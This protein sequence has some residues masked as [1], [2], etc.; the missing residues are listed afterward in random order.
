MNATQA[1]SLSLLEVLERQG[2]SPCEIRKAGRELW[3]LSPFRDEKTP[4]FSV[5]V[6]KNIWN[7]F[8]ESGV[9]NQRCAGGKVI[10][11]LIRY[12]NTD[13][14]DA[15]AQVNRL[16]ADDMAPLNAKP[17]CY[18][19][20]EKNANP[21]TLTSVKEVFSDA[22]FEYM[23]SRKIPSG[24]GLKYLK[25]VQYANTDTGKKN[26]GLGFENRKG[27]YE[28]RNTFFKGVVGQKD[29]TIIKG[30]RDSHHVQLIEGMFDFLSLLRIYSTTKPL[31]DVIILNGAS[32]IHVAIEEVKK[33]KYQ[34]AQSWFD[35]DKGG[36]KATEILKKT[37][38][39]SALTVKTQ[40][41]K[42]AEYKDVNE[43]CDNLNLSD[44]R[45]QF[46]LN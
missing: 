36:R 10:D 22:L 41:H 35:N 14:K 3:F 40:H 30:A 20:V 1:K 37:F 18:G 25:Q 5:D 28:I 8:G 34:K 33:R 43:M 7:D 45:S 23:K 2:Y 11:Y 9:G 27:G 4:S 44:V 6:S 16:F 21:L 32:M 12:H 38:E 42:Y 46:G 19:K 24:V 29:I 17:V 13:V 26:F 31:S 15:L 39:D